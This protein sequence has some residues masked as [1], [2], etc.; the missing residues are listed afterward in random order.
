M[1]EAPDRMKVRIRATEYCGIMMP[2]KDGEYEVE[3]VWKVMVFGDH[4]LLERASAYDCPWPDGRLA[5]QT[6]V[7]EMRRLMVKRN[8]LDW[9]LE[10]PIER[11]NG[12]MTPECYKAVGLTHAPVL[13]ALLDRFEESLHVSADEEEQIARQ[14]S[15]L[16]GKSGGSVYDACEA[17]SL[18][19]TLGNYSDKF[20]VDRDA[21]RD[22][23]YR[24]YIRL[25]IVMNKE[26]DSVKRQAKVERPSNTK[27]IAGHGGRARPSRAT[28]VRGP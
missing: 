28:V 14:C 1:L 3:A 16:F 19:C 6:D 21:L 20:G 2:F 17:V 25:K 8:L 7:N 5:Q 9:N 26:G 13:E 18:F 22:M 11:E 4:W 12:W 24:E 10:T 27:I 15:Q 23:P